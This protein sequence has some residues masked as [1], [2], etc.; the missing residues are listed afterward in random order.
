VSIASGVK[1]LRR[2]R[3]YRSSR[4]RPAWPALA[5]RA[6]LD[7]RVRTIA[8]AYLFAIVGYVNP[9]A[10]RTAYPTL[11]SR[12]AF[13]HSFANNKAVVLFYGKA[14]NLLTV[15]GYAAWR[16]GGIL[17]IFAGVFGLLAAVR[18]LRT[19]EETGRA[20]LVLSGVV[21]RMTVFGSSLVAIGAGTTVL[22]VA[23]LAGLLAGGLPIGD[24]ALLALATTTVVPV[25]VGAGAIASQLAPTRRMALELGTGAIVVAF[26]VR[27]I[28]DTSN[29]GWLR[30]ATPLGWAEEVRPFTGPHPV[31]LLLP[32]AAS[33][34]LL[35]I[36]A[37]IQT[38]RDIGAGL[39]PARDSSD[40]RL[41][42]LSSPTAHA[43]REERTSLIVWTLSVTAAAL[44]I[45][46]VSKS[47][48]P[49]VISKGLQRELAK[50]GEGSVVTPAGYI[51]FAFIFVVL[52]LALF[53]CAQVAAARTEEAEERLETLLALPVGRRSWLAGRLG[54]AL[55]AAVIICLAAG[56]FTWVGAES[57]GV[58]LSLP[59]LLGAGAN[60]LPVTVLFLGLAALAY[61]LVPRASTGIAY[62]LV[63]VAF[64]WY[65]FGSLV[66]V[67]H[68]LV[69]ATPFAHV[70]AVP[71]QSFR[72]G[73]AAVMVGVG[74]AA[75]II[76]LGVF[77]RRDLLGT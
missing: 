20:E 57:A 49:S 53:A 22:F 37:R 7:A 26:L 35:A 4:P 14:Y 69:E 21:G 77:Q 17:A 18:A 19:E 51:A 24:S 66:G 63:A 65:L 73:A 44:I 36:A 2:R 48:N 50:F 15:G 34:A 47:I 46:I 6:A 74:L 41:S 8:F 72:A 12:A 9:A 43:L 38:S 60:C 25:F 61:A 71:V 30:W 42:L 56:L 52:V 62:G 45:G 23:E 59:K 3:D 54:L 67:P 10:Y 76:A 75:A 11:A 16:T 64:L 13:A 31:V 58:R 40:P 1:S 5:R 33:G 29:I 39:L 28:A 32:L 68:W 70:A 27:V 55:A